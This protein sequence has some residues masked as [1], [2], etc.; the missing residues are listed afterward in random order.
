MKRGL[1]EE[2]ASRVTDVY[3]RATLRG[4]GHHEIDSLPGRFDHLEKGE[5]NPAASIT[6]IGGMGAL[7]LYDGD[8]GMGELCSL[9]AT[10]RSMEL[11]ASQGIG[12]VSVRNSNH[13]LAA[14][15][16]TEYA[17][18][19]GFF[20]TIL[21][22]SP[23]GLTIPGAGKD[24]MG[25]NP[26]GYSAAAADGSLLFDVCFSYS[27]F[28]KMGLLARQGKSIPSY[29][30][31]DSEG[32]PTENPA[33]VLESKLYL[34]MGEHKGFGLAMWVELMTSVLGG[35]TIL[36]DEESKLPGMYTQ[37]AISINTEALPGPGSM[38]ERTTR[39]K[40]LFREMYPEIYFPGQGSLR[41]KEAILQQGFV[42]V[43]PEL[44]QT[45]T[46]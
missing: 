34:A 25:N 30:G 16:Y 41:N 8:N 9:F 20:T 21:S 17:E 19:K 23:S 37:T 42:E 45:I 40:E 32:Q 15:P 1:N 22:K 26:F 46:A 39:M 13:F 43:D 29:W 3:Y 11:A 36:R 35:G 5:T 6:K 12:F 4:V 24:L 18:E 10:E 38:A 27:S 28:G 31:E 44:W 2:D 14:A 7:E 33:D